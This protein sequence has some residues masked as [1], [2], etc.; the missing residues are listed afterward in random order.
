[1]EFDLNDGPFTGMSG[2]SNT[3]EFPEVLTYADVADLLWTLP[4]HEYLMGVNGQGEPETFNL[5]DDSPHMFVSASPG[6]GKSVIAASVATQALVKGSSVMFLDVKRISHRWAKEL[7]AVTYAVEI[8][9]IANGIVSVAA[10]L[11]RRM[12]IIDDYPG[13][14][15]D[16]P[17]GDRIVVI[18]E[19][20][21]AMMAQL[22]EFEKLLPPR[23]VYRPRQALTDI[24][25]LGRAAKVHVVAFAQFP[26]GRLIPKPMIESFGHRVLIKHTNESWKA[27]A[28]QLGYSSPSPQQRGR[29]LTI[30]GDR[31]VTTQFLFL[32]EEQCAALV[33]MARGDDKRASVRDRLIQKRGA[34]RELR[35]VEGR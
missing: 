20:I 23:G 28:W 3:S 22:A 8:D 2:A 32:E 26:D 25:N 29:G 19:E 16:A 5:I 30:R 12:R 35:A 31:A 14:I 10:E 15:S 18:V 1:M 7:P 24:L 11:R 27:L 4:E 34:L 13:A 9:E 21:N 33:R 17:V 6:S